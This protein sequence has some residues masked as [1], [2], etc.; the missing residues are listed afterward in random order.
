M[1]GKP[2]VNTLFVFEPCHSARDFRSFNM[3][4]NNKQSNVKSVVCDSQDFRSYV[5]RKQ[6]IKCEINGVDSRN[7]DKRLEMKHSCR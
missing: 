2:L 7:N 6:A 5:T 1:T 3:L 4:G